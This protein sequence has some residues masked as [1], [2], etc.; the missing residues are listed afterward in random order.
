MTGFLEGPAANGAFI[1]CGPPGF[2]ALAL[3]RLGE[4]ARAMCVYSPPS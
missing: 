3:I 4:E 2:T 1:I